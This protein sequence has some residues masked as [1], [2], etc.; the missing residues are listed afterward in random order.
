MAV[1]VAQSATGNGTTTPAT[2]TSITPTA[3]NLLVV[4]ICALGTSPTIATPTGGNFIQVQKVSGTAL[5]MAMY[6]LP[7]NPGG[8]TVASSVL[9]GTVTG[10]I[11]LIVEFSGATIDEALL[12]SANL[13]NSVAALA[14]IFAGNTQIGQI[15]ELFLYAVGR[16]T[17]TIT[18]AN[19]FLNWSAS[20]NAL[21]GVQG[22]SLDLY[23]A[24]APGPGP[25]PQ[26]SGT[27]S[28]AVNS[29]QIGAWLNSDAAY[30][31]KMTNVG[32]TAGIMIPQFNQGMIGG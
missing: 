25:F 6:I 11:S 17:A 32:G 5:T 9:G 29:V 3:K 16:A 12:S 4:V 2:T 28:G 23:W 15:N 18:T 27:L 19:L 31:I 13:S 20:V 26:A 30:P 1:A 14:N 10:W 21:A 7:N 22:M 8:A 24:V